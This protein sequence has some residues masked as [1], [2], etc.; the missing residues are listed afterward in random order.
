M[1]RRFFGNSENGS[2]S[3]NSSGYGSVCCAFEFDPAMKLF[4]T[5]EFKGQRHIVF[6]EDKRRTSP[7]SAFEMLCEL[8][9]ANRFAANG[10]L[11]FRDCVAACGSE[12]NFYQLAYRVRQC[13]GGVSFLEAGPKRYRLPF[14]PENVGL[15]PRIVEMPELNPKIAAKL[16]QCL[17]V[18]GLSTD[19]D[20]DANGDRGID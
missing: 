7:F 1:K 5:S 15:C 11:T 17:D 3:G 14:L 18:D 10:Y 12:D 16:R 13:L 9:W 19:G 4:V 6:V 8:V 2:D 20:G